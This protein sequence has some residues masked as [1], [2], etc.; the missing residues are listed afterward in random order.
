MLFKQ[1]PA[2]MTA[3][4]APSE[5]PKSSTN[6]SPTLKTEDKDEMSTASPASQTQACRPGDDDMVYP[7]G[8]KLVLL[9]ICMFVGMFLVSLDKL[10][11][12]TAIPQITN[13]FNSAGDIGWYG[14]AYLLTSCAFQLVFGKIYAY[15]SIKLTFM[16]SVLLF[17]IG[18]T[19]CGAAPNSITFIV[20]RAVAGLGAGGVMA[21]VV[22]LSLFPRTV[23]PLA[24]SQHEFHSLYGTNETQSLT[25]FFSDGYHRLC[26]STPQTAQSPRIL[27]RRLRNIIHRRPSH[28]WS[29][30]NQGN[31]EGLFL[32]EPASR[33]GCPGARS[34]PARHSGSSK[35]K[36]S[37]GGKV[38]TAER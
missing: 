24:I 32:F 36:D 22:S 16:A 14:T 21:G 38:A 28:R 30:H 20:G 15:F 29:F 12:S 2:A 1:T 25:I 19:L 11:I 26:T 3:T 10:I 35:Y 4:S 17:E 9:L 33:S 13:D 37:I 5:L 31:M 34:L 6:A 8:L 7:T 18:S 23:F 27:W